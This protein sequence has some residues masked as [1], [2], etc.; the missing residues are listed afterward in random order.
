MEPHT[1]IGKKRNP[2]HEL[3][4]LMV[5]MASGIAC[6]KLHMTAESHKMVAILKLM[7]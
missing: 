6:G 5:I 3:I 2:I 7:G 1:H 4:F